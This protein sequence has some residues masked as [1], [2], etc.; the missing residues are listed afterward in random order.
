MADSNVNVRHEKIKQLMR[1]STKFGGGDVTKL[2]ALPGTV[3]RD[4][5]LALSASQG[6]DRVVSD[7]IDA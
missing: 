1:V 6:I 3:L 7:A 2:Q 5:A 4:F